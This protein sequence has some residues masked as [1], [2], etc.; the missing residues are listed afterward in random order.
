MPR[1]ARIE[2]R[3]AA[4]WLTLFSVFAIFE[5]VERQVR[6]TLPMR[7][8]VLISSKARAAF[9]GMS[10]AGRVKQRTKEAPLHSFAY[11]A[12]AASGLSARLT[13]RA[14][15]LTRYPLTHAAKQQRCAAADKPLAAK[16]LTHAAKQ[17]PSRATYVSWPLAG[18]YTLSRSTLSVVIRQARRRQA[19][20]RETADALYV[21]ACRRASRRYTLLASGL[22]ARR[23]DKL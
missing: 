1:L 5:R 7:L 16:Q 13:G 22:S 23:Y 3:S 8:L 6:L 17:P 10:W 21:I 12:S 19:A 14:T 11:Q 18:R 20:S 9:A 15:L 4:G 2:A